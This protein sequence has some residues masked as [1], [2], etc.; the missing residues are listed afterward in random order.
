MRY[1]RMTNKDTTWL[2]IYKKECRCYYKYESA[3]KKAEYELEET[4]QRIKNVKSPITDRASGHPTTTGE[5][6]L[7]TLIE[8]KTEVEHQIAYYHTIMCWIRKVNE[9]ISSPAYRA[10][11]WQ[12]LIQAKNRMDLLINY[13]VDPEYVYHMRDKFLMVALNETMQEQYR[14][15]QKLKMKSKWLSA[16]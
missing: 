10:I 8:I 1:L 11:T 16:E 5:E 9:N 12:T 6:R 3:L 4:E 15:I 14:E 7:L 2:Q 13:D